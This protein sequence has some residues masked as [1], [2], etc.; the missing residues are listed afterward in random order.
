[1][2][3]ATNA[4]L[5]AAVE[6]GRFR[7]DLYYRLRVVEL[8]VPPLRDRCEDV[9]P[10]ARSFLNSAA[11][12]SGRPVPALS[13][14]AAK[15]LLAWAWPGNVRELENAME[16]AVALA[17]GRRLDVED[18]PPELRRMGEL[19]TGRSTL[20]G[21]APDQRSSRAPGR[22]MSSTGDPGISV[23]RCSTRTGSCVAS[24]NEKRRSRVPSTI[25]IS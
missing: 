9:L 18:L 17:R 2:I 14:A 4:D 7:K 3:P 25:F 19:P 16:R 8:L 22:T 24:S 10:L 11:A 5:P 15:R 21:S 6:A 20:V 1:M 12:R 13:N 23:S